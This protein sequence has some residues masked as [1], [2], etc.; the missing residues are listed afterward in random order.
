MKSFIICFFC[1]NVSIEK[2]E[3]VTDKKRQKEGID[4]VISLSNWDIYYVDDKIREKDYEDILIEEWFNYEMRN[5]F[6]D[7]TMN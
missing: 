1:E 4:K 6:D 7:L 2:I 3:V 5:M